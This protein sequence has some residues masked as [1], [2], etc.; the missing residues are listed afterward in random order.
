MGEIFSTEIKCFKIIIES[1][2]R[3]Y[4]YKKKKTHI[5]ILQQ[6][7]ET[8]Y[9]LPNLFVG[10]LTVK[11]IN[12]AFKNGISGDNILSF[13]RN[14]LHHVC[15]I[16]PSNVIEQIKIWE[17]DKRSNFISKVIFASNLNKVWSS[18]LNYNLNQTIV[19]RTIRINKIIIFKNLIC[20]L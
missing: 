16:I 6:F 18:S 9:Q 10:D 5:D 4:A 2:F 20:H 11:S 17:L 12:K 13:I 8:L 14:N 1:N 19:S 15:K 3:L 7:S